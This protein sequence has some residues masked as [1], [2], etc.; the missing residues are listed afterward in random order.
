[1]PGVRELEG[2]VAAIH[3]DA[4]LRSR[5]TTGVLADAG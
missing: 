1:V 4:S 3:P 5:T 2:E